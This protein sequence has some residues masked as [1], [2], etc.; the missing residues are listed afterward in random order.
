[1]TKINNTIRTLHSNHLIPTIVLQYQSDLMERGE[2]DTL[3]PSTLFESVEVRDNVERYVRLNHKT[4]LT[5]KQP[6]PIYRGING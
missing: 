3:P 2:T 1:M 5:K 6:K 4:I